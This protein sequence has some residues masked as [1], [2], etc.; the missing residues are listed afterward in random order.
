M[1]KGNWKSAWRLIAKICGLRVARIENDGK[2]E[3]EKFAD[4]SKGIKGIG[5]KM[6]RIKGWERRQTMRIYI[7]LY[8]CVYRGVHLYIILILSLYFSLDR[9]LLNV[10]MYRYG[11]LVFFW[12]ASLRYTARQCIKRFGNNMT[13]WWSTCRL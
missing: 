3:A 10:C 1:R 8:T 7:Y 5:G 2:C 13:L 9:P 6:K 11:R 4:I 12:N